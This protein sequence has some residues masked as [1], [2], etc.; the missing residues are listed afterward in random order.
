[1]ARTRSASAHEKVIWAAAELFAERGVDGASM[2]AIAE[3]ST[4]SKATIYKHWPDKNALLLEVLEQVNGLKAR[5]A[6]DSGNIRVDI[7]DVLA[8]RPTEHAELRARI[9]PHL[10]AFSAKNPDLGDLWR[11]RVMDPPRRELT[12]LLKAA[13]KAGQLQEIDVEGSLALLIGPMMYWFLFLRRSSENPRPLAESVVDTFWRAY[14]L[15]NRR[16]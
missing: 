13:I 8:Y 6:F 12:R 16:R 5:P 1:M 7:T 4:V 14:A 11:K 3:E 10:M 2:D 15:P 9:M